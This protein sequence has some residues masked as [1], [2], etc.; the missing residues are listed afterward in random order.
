MSGHAHCLGV[1]LYDLTFPSSPVAPRVNVVA[2]RHG[3]MG[4]GEPGERETHPCSSSLKLQKRGARE[5]VQGVGGKKNRRFHLY[6]MVLFFYLFANVQCNGLKP[7]RV[8]AAAH[9]Q[10][11]SATEHRQASRISSIGHY[12]RTHTRA[13]C[14]PTPWVPPPPP[15]P[16]TPTILHTQFK[17]NFQHSVSSR[18]G[19]KRS[20]GTH[21]TRREETRASSEPPVFR[22]AR[23]PPPACGLTTS[24]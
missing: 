19:R 24:R 17:Q 11:C 5:R 23:Q 6:R 20:K 16:P 18:E 4:W 15:A 21:G 1:G 3:V 14:T 22:R 13:G 12:P 2:R 9:T 10:S 8:A 7:S